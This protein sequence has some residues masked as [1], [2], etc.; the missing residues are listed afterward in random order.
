MRILA[1]FSTE[2]L[3]DVGGHA[4]DTFGYLGADLAG[5]IRPAEA[6]KCPSAEISQFGA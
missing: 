4:I 5:Q 1:R 6:P 3:E 2:E